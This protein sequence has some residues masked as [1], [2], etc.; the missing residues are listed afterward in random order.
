[1]PDT[2]TLELGDPGPTLTLKG[3]VQT[4]A[5]AAVP[6]AQVIIDDDLLPGTAT[7]RSK[8]ATTDATGAFSLDTLGGYTELTIVP[9]PNSVAGVTHAF[10]TLPPSV[11]T[12]VPSVF[13]CVDRML[14]TGVVLKPDGSKAVG[15]GVHAI[16]R[17]A[18]AGSTQPLTLDN[19]DA[20]TDENGAYA[21]YLDPA[22]WRIEFYPG[23]KYPMVSRLVTLDSTDIYGK[24]VPPPPLE[25]VTLAAGRTVQGTVTGNV[26]Q[27]A[28]PLPYATL[29][30]FRV[31]PVGG[32]SVA[33]LIGSTVADDKGNYTIVL[34]DR[35]TAK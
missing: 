9:P 6:G 24:P 13:K 2:V 7:F 10:F 15:V 30:F 28:T 18:T 32:T 26:A 12:P 20:V 16:E 19:V 27:M 21:L 11:T 4:S 14:V 22:V 8:L 23:S 34:P 31:A 17:A 25:T 33:T 35:S 3:V 29:R 5:G 1:V